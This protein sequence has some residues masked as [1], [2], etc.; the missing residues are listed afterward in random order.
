MTVEELKQFFE[1]STIH[2]LY[3][4]SSTRRWSRLFWILTVIGGFSGAGY[5]IY[6]SFDNWAQSPIST[7]VETLPISQITFPNVTVC[8]PKNLF[9]NLNYD[10][11]QSEKMKLE[12]DTRH[13]FI[14]TDLYE[15]QEQFYDEIMTNFNKVEDPD[16]Y[17]NW[18]HG[19]TGIGYPKY[20]HTYLSNQ[21]KYILYTSATSGNISTKYFGEKF[22]ADKVE[23]RIYIDIR[24]IFP[25]SFIYDN[26]VTLMLNVDKITM[27]DVSGNDMMAFS[28]YVCK[29]E[30]YI[31]I[32]IDVT[33]W[34]K[35]ITAPDLENYY[36]SIRLVRKLSQDVIKNM[37]LDLMPGFRFTWNYNKLIE[38]DAT[39]IIDGTTKEFVR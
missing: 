26:N 17:H 16:R 3:Y 28:C 39:F 24:V 31:D 10:I 35:Y 11:L 21:L 4:I 6:E 34:T 30:Y 20:D 37:K 1:S 38:Q 2:G 7:T 33:N 18:Y 29:E 13:K 9:L 36:F 23:G 27:K 12:N 22:D 5:L 15:V 32:D 25:P 14:A 19:Y 8:P